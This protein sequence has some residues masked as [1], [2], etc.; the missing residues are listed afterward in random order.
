MRVLRR[1][2]LLVGLAAGLVLVAVTAVRSA[3]PFFLTAVREITFDGMQRLWPREAGESPVRIVD[4]DEASIAAF[5][6]WPWPRNRLASLTERLGELG[7]AAI[8]FDVVFPEP[9]RSS[10]ATVTRTMDFGGSEEALR[11]RTFIATLP[12]HDRQFAQAIADAPVILGFATLAQPNDRRP[13]P[14][15]GFSYGGR[16]PVEFLPAFQGALTSLPML[17]EPAS[18]SGGVSLSIQ[19]TSGVVRR[20]PLLFNDGGRLYPGLLA[21]TLRVAQGAGGFLLRTSSASGEADGGVPAV[22]DMRVGAFT[23]PTTANGELWLHFDH[24]RPE[25]YVSAADLFDP[26]KDETVRDA[27]DGHIVFI[28]TSAVGLSDIRVTPLGELVPGVLVHAQAAE[29]VISGDYLSRPD[30]A[31]G[32][33]IIITAALGA[34]ILATLPFLGAGWTAAFGAGIAAF[35]FGGAGYLF[36]RQGL[37]LDPVYPALANLMVYAIATALLYLLTERERRFVR[38]AFSQYLAPELVSRLE[39]SP[40]GLQLGGEMRDMSILFMDVRGFTP[41]SEQ[42]TPTELVTFLNTLLTPLSDAILSEAGTIDKYI[43]DSVMAFW[44]APVTI[45]DHACHAC[46]AALAMLDLVERLNADDAFGFRKNGMSTREVR[47]GIGINS[48]MACVGNMGSSRR[49]NYSVIG[50]AVNIAA[51]IE[52]S[53]KDVG[54]ECLVSE[55][56]R[57]LAPDFA[58]LEAGAIPL[59][60]KSQPIRLFALAGTPEMAATAEFTALA[61]A[62]AGLID[63]LSCA[64]PAK[65]QA[66]LARCQEIAPERL[67]SFYT[68]FAARVAELPAYLQ[69][70]K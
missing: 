17:E 56:T 2:R 14:K 12:D 26:A 6:Q 68:R 7:A 3:D 44:N 10:P 69:A 67:S 29:Q 66:A 57:E 46:R 37:L 21:E 61:T 25:R 55:A 41:I 8:A 70:G 5:G 60:G 38:T 52:A 53:C 33:E 28:G 27:I 36:T 35:I 40:E 30:W 1:K 45:E 11:A 24:D 58:Y 49:F 59:K 32:L 19:D 16:N 42:L 23:I 62:H 63:A 65:A 64:N 48:G 54:A 50:D 13:A 51:R 18:G 47:I 39:A 34:V 43:G 22:T 31:Y 4:I 20:I 9:D 15:A